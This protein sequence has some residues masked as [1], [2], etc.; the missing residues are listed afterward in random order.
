MK[1]NC[2]ACGA[3]GKAIAEVTN[4]SVGTY[5]ACYT[6]MSNGRRPPCH[7]TCGRPSELM[8]FDARWCSE[9]YDAHRLEQEKVAA[10]VLAARITQ[11]EAQ[12]DAR[13]TARIEAVLKARGL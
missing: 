13:I 2:E 1:L 8:V 11:A 5:L 6:C 3:F 12:F 10:Q 4:P 9:C 7:K